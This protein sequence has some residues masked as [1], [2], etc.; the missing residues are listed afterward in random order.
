MLNRCTSIVALT[1]STSVFAS[2]SLEPDNSEQQTFEEALMRDP[3]AIARNI[4][5]TIRSSQLRR[6]EF[7]DVI[8]GGNKYQ[9]WQN[10]DNVIIKL[11]ELTPIRDSPLRWSSTFLMIE[12]FL[13]LEQVF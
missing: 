8:R 2:S 1:N 13:Y 12:C 4:V 3:I 10:S 11:E 5:N 7:Q 9:R 6:V